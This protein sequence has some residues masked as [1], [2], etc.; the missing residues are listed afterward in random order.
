M[1]LQLRSLLFRSSSI[2]IA[3]DSPHPAPLFFFQ[4]FPSF[5]LL[6]TFGSLLKCYHLS[7]YIHLIVECYV[8]ILP[9]VQLIHPPAP[10]ND[11]KK[12]F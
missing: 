6:Y 1:P 3:V 8:T 7:G 5:M 12:C 2:A 9:F 4:Q 11:V 10:A